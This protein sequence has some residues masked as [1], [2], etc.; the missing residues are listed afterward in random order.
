LEQGGKTCSAVLKNTLKGE[1][2]ISK[3]NWFNIIDNE[4]Y[5]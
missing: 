2:E 4:E 1:K 5:K 3:N